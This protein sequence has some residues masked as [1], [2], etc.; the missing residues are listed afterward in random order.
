MFWQFTSDINGS[1]T[2]Q[3]AEG[4]LTSKTTKGPIS[5]VQTKS[6]RPST[7]KPSKPIPRPKKR[8]IKH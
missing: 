7:G 2:N 6:G 4:I 1:F 5:A 3:V 8:V